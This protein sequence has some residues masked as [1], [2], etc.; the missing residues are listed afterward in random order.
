MFV[1]LSPFRP[2]ARILAVTPLLA[3]LL[4]GCA[5]TTISTPPSSSTPALT[6]PVLNLTPAVLFEAQVVT[7]DLGTIA[8]GAHSAIK[9]IA[10]PA[11][12]LV[13]SGGLATLDNAPLA[14][15]S[16]AK[17]ALPF[18]PLSGSPSRFFT[19]MWNAP[20][21]PTT[22]RVEVYNGG[23]AA[24]TAQARVEC[25]K[26]AGLQSQ[27][28]A[29]L[30][31]TIAPNTNSAIKDTACPAGYFVAGGGPNS[32]YAPFT[33]MTSAPINTTTWRAEVWNRSAGSISV[34]IQ[35]VCLTASGLQ[36]QFQQSAGTSVSSGTLLPTVDLPCPAGFRL[37]GGGVSSGYHT[38][39]ITWNA[40]LSTTTLR[41]QVYN[42]GAST[43]QF[44]ARMVCMQR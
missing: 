17:A 37:A 2:L 15:V 18:A 3:F 42:D 26:T 16:S 20:I 36:A 19:S 28:V 21:N 34:Q 22:W 44:T 7:V 4:A 14:S 25:L 10:C 5:V 39:N 35:I 8:P 1:S 27:I 29:T 33:L 32:G 23:G 12:Y 6:P 31:S 9:D 11:G 13:A 40:P 43:I 38:F 24:A 41:T 30:F